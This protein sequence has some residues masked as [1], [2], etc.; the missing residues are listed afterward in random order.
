MDSIDAD[1][2]DVL[3]EAGDV[4]DIDYSALGLSEEEQKNLRELEEAA[5]SESQFTAD[6]L[7]PNIPIPG[8]AGEYVVLRRIDSFEVRRWRQM[9]SDVRYKA[10][11][12]DNEDES[13][14]MEGSVKPQLAA[15]FLYLCQAGVGEYC[16]TVGGQLEKGS[17][18]RKVE[19]ATERGDVTKEIRRVFG[20]L[21]P[22]TGD[23]LERVLMLF[24][25]LTRERR[26]A[27]NESEA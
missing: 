15:S 6:E 7:I 20:G 22:N 14:E 23:W 26:A 4:Q 10:K 27:R 21:P 13:N 25:G 12:T 19:G 1:A 11:M 24:N 17:F 9:A 2:T 16:V 18:N 8:R 5:A 3:Q